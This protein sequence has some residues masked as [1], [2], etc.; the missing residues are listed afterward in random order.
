MGNGKLPSDCK[1]QGPIAQNLRTQV[2]VTLVSQPSM[3]LEMEKLSDCIIQHQ[4]LRVCDVE[5]M[6]CDAKSRVKVIVRLDMLT[7]S[8]AQ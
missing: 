7:K 2:L 4:T 5:Y 8:F 6:F 1:Q 3:L